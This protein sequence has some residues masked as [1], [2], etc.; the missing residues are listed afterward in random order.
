MELVQYIRLFR[1]WYWLILIAA[2]VAGGIGFVVRSGQPAL[3][4]AQTTIAI[5]SFIQ[6]PN[7][8][9]AEIRTGVELAQTYAELAKTYSVLQATIDTLGV[10]L[11]ADELQKI[12]QVRILP[13]TSLLV[14]SVTYTDP[15]L[16][17]DIANEVAR[18]LI[19]NS[20][21]NLTPEQQ[22]QIDL[23]NDQIDR[24]TAQSE[25]AR[26]QLEL[27]DAQITSS[28]DPAE[29]ER[30]TTQRNA[31]VDQT[32][33]ASATIAQFS[34]T[35]AN[36]QQRTNSLD[37]VEPARVP[38][39]QTGTSILVTT[40]LAAIV[41]A[42]L[43]VGLVLLVEY[44]DDSIRTTED[45]AQI[46]TLPVLGAIVRFG[47]PKDDYP[48]RLI[49][50]P[51]LIFSPASEGYR[52]IRTN[53]LFSSDGAAQ[54]VYLITSPGPEEGKSLTAANLALSMALAEM[55]V[56]L[57]DADLRRPTIHRI[58]GLS[59]EVGLTTLFA[60]SKRISFNP[61]DADHTQLSQALAK[62]I[63]QT[64]VPTLK[65]LTGGFIPHN[66][67]ELLGSS[68][69]QLWAGVLRN[70]PDFD[71]V[72]MDTPPCLLLSDSV[73]LAASTNADVL[74]IL[75]AGRTRR[76]SALKAK[77][78][79]DQTGSTIKGVILNKV[80][81]REE[82]YYGYGYYTYYH[83]VPIEQMREVVISHSAR[84]R[85]EKPAKQ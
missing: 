52:A 39:D 65:V 69:M 4:Q 58:F 30:L 48:A 72:L 66:P 77:E 56:L 38:V 29:I 37:I 75:A 46:L 7:P 43:A 74:L 70:S 3:Y 79:F 44:L 71:V 33:Q 57:I 23:A 5:G 28:E 50:S 81:P 59:N 26:L 73:V 21:T 12:I 35:I 22:S 2:F 41:G 51:S 64:P 17:A 20:P 85:P 19:V 61:L 40:L 80:N 32:N 49:T 16:A 15:I 27:I 47:E 84:N 8:D 45:A 83:R 78:Q 36:L 24:L 6:A 67:V 55:R 1:K 9:T 14:L 10:P 13:G 60:A 53:L 31:L 25:E 62:C 68:L 54:K 18:Q 82:P 42:T 34:S 63:Q 11:T 76:N